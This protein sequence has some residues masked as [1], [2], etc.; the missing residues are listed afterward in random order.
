MRCAM[1]SILSRLALFVINGLSLFHYI[2]QISLF[3]S[4]V[5][6]TWLKRVEKF[7]WGL[8]GHLSTYPQRKLEKK[9]A[10]VHGL[11]WFG[12]ARWYSERLTWRSCAWSNWCCV[13]PGSSRD[14][15]KFEEKY[16]NKCIALTSV[17]VLKSSIH[18]HALWTWTRAS[19]V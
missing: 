2:F 9:L 8:K 5:K 7:V 11:R 3:H 13:S 15:S 10:L 12:L 1:A 14:C 4:I 6:N 19:S 16:R 18:V 17:W